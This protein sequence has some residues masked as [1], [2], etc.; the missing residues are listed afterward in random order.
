MF[1][2]CWLCHISPQAPSHF[3][4][5]SL[6][7]YRCQTNYWSCLKIRWTGD[8]MHKRTRSYT[9][10]KVHAHTCCECKHTIWWQDT[11]DSVLLIII[12]RARWQGTKCCYRSRAAMFGAKQPST[13]RCNAISLCIK[14][15]QCALSVAVP[16]ASCL[17]LGGNEFCLWR[18]TQTNACNH[19]KRKG[20]N[21]LLCLS[22]FEESFRVD[23]KVFLPC[24]FEQKVS[25]QHCDVSHF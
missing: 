2:L 12:Y 3:L 7:C 4:P 24:S 15:I 14:E 5:S 6:T 8:S 19:R 13:P 21:A 17:L 23:F 1:L 16:R 11:Q 25:L 10:T 9:G 18:N 20:I 22:G